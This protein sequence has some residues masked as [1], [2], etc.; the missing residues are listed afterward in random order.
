MNASEGV[1][2]AVWVEMSPQY[3]FADYALEGVTP[4][5]NQILMEVNI[6]AMAKT[7]GQ[8]KSSGST[9]PKSLKVTCRL[10]LHNNCIH[11]LSKYLLRKS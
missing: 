10:M 5:D 6:D 3:Y 8:L 4:E 7:L 9:A 2:C 11:K 1:A